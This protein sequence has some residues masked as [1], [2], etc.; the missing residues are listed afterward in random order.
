LAQAIANRLRSH[1]AELS[2][3]IDPTVRTRIN[4]WAL[5]HGYPQIPAGYTN[6]Q[7]IVD[8]C[9]VFGLGNLDQ[10]DVLE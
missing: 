2:D 3:T 4:T 6:R 7:T 5:L 9:N 10:T 8:I 1:W